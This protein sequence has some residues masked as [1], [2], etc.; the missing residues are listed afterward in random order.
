MSI[1]SAG[2]LC[3]HSLLIKLFSLLSCYGRV[4]TLN[5]HVVEGVT[6]QVI[7]HCMDVRMYCYLG[8][9][10]VG[11]GENLCP[12]FH[13]E[14]VTDQKGVYRLRGLSVSVGSCW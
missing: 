13:E 12:E 14:A 5:G 4:L 6:V 10:V 1:T 9:Q 2:A 8:S 11:S 3:I 7:I